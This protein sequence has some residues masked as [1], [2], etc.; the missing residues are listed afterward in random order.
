MASDKSRTGWYYLIIVVLL[1]MFS[2]IANPS[3]SLKIWKFFI[4]LSWNMIPIFITVFLL[5]AIT[6][7]LFEPKSLI[8][9]MGKDSGIKGW[10]I[11]IVAGTLSSGPIYMWY[12]L[13][14]DL[15]EKGMK[16]SLI[17]CFLYNRA[18]KI[19]LIPLM[20]L[21]F[22]FKYVLILTIVMIFTSILAG[23]T[24]EFILNLKGGK[25]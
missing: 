6:N 2:L 1:L 20:I 12:P 7:Y 8:K 5:M 17:T 15:K 14:A 25:K 13:L 10:L 19:P 23:I 18:I 22:S 24:V 11:A 3:S 16:I 9:H 21:Y 4:N